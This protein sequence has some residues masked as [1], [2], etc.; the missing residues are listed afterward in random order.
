MDILFVSPY[1]KPAY[2][3]GGPVQSISNLCE[4]LA[5]AGALVKVFTTNANGSNKLDVPLHQPMQMGGVLVSYF[6]LDYNGLTFFYSSS[7]T[8]EILDRVSEFDIIIAESL[9]GHALM[10]ISKACNQVHKPYV[11]SARGQLNSWALAKKNLKKRLYLTLV[12]RRLINQAAAIYCTDPLEATAVKKLRFRPP[13][14]EIPNGIRSSEYLQRNDTC[15]LRDRYGIPSDA[16]L[17][18]FLGRMTQIKRPD[19]AVEVLGATQALPQNIHL[20]LVGPDEGNW[21]DRLKAQAQVL[22]CSGKIHFT[23]LVDRKG[24]ISALSQANLLLMPSEIQENFGNS[25]LE[26]MAAGV[27]VI[28]SDGVPVGYWAEKAG[29]G[30]V[31]PC[32]KDAFQKATLDLLSNPVQLKKMGELG[33]ELIQ[34]RFDVSIVSHEMLKQYEAIVANGK[35]MPITEINNHRY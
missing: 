19:I 10:P 17:L 12:G 24:V 25:A 14:F 28:V 35:P 20:L 13:P 32:T 26:A 23:G 7:L 4:G 31:V 5:Q 27:P 21:K 3:Y 8:K 11:V 9:W 15:N 33:Q 2:V 30:R 1:Y 22:N 18:L 6:P 29:A 16:I 34:E